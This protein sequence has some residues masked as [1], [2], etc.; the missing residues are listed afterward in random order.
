MTAP[1]IQIESPESSSP[2]VTRSVACT[3]TGKVFN[4]YSIPGW[5][6][7]VLQLLGR[8][9]QDIGRFVIMRFESF[10]GLD[11]HAL[12]SLSM[13]TLAGARLKDYDELEGQFPVI[14]IGA[15]LGGASAFLS[16][17]LNSPFLPQ[18]FVTTLKGGSMDGNVRTYLQCAASLALQIANR[19]P[20]LVTIQHY[21]PIHDEWMTRRVNHLRFKLL[22]LPQAYI[23]FI[24]RR[25]LPGGA[26]CYLDCGA[27]WLH[28][29]LGERSV[30]QV[31]GWG[32]ISAEEFLEGSERIH[33]Y[34]AS[35]GLE[36]TDW[37]LPEYP[38]EGGPESEWGTEPG[39][40]EAIQDFCQEEGYQ[41]VR[42]ALPE[43]HYYSLLAYQSMVRLLELEGREPAGALVEMFSQFDPAPALKSGLLPLWLIF[44]TWDSLKFL[45]LMRSR[46]PKGKPIFFS[47]LSTFTR[48]PDL[49]PWSEWEAALQGLDWHNLGTRP[50][51]YPADMLTLIDWAKPLREWAEQHKHPVQRRLTAEELSHLSVSLQFNP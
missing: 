23:Q 27:Q 4:P 18:A 37:R 3:L 25:L 13:E 5:Q 36:K 1:L 47:P 33:R 7:V 44:N 20:G 6:K 26:V 50:D 48:T 14:T 49:V 38:L 19:N 2:L 12:D 34:A 51:H 24:R 11:P 35:I 42:I 28:Y 16:L 43:P 29:K 10:S 31:G 21:D 40:G 32:D 45:K 17:A 22:Q 30:F 39:F 8:L 46:F 9:P 41:F 15:A